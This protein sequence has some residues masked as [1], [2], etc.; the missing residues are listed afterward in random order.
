MASRF[1]EI[2]EPLELLEKA[3]PASKSFVKDLRFDKVDLAELPIEF[4]TWES[5]DT[6]LIYF[7]DVFADA[8]IINADETSKA[9]MSGPHKNIE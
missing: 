3:R 2:L 1:R 7:T 8:R 9:F 4:I 6:N 5:R